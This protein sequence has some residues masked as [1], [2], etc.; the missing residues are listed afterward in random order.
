[1]ME[2]SNSQ[3]PIILVVEDD[4]SSQMLVKFFLRDVL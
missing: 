2:K 4:I 1:M 3:K